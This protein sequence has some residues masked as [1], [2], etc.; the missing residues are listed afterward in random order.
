M[1][2]KRWFIC[3]NATKAG[4]SMWSRWAM[5][6]PFAR[7]RTLALDGFLLHQKAKVR[8]RANGPGIAH[9]DHIDPPAFVAF[10]Q[11]NQ[12]FG[13]IRA[14]GHPVVQIFHRHR[15]CRGEQDRFDHAFLFTHRGGF[16][17][18]LPILTLFDWPVALKLRV[19]GHWASVRRSSIGA[20]ASDWRIS[21]LPS[22]TNSSDAAKVEAVADRQ[23]AGSAS[24]PSGM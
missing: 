8:R 2:P 13:R 1:R 15:L 19:V 22:F 5:P 20:K 21:T 7:R 4:G 6:G 18:A 9:L 12:R 16:E 17:Q 24:Q 10:A 11:M 23:R 14:V 3:A